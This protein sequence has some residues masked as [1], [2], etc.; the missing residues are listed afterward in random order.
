VATSFLCGRGVEQ[1]KRIRDV[2]QRLARA[3]VDFGDADLGAIAVEQVD[4]VASFDDDL[5]AFPDLT[6]LLPQ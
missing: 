5:Q 1:R 3:N 6:T 4:K 2:L